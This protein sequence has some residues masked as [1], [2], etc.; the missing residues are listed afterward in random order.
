MEYHAC[1]RDILLLSSIL[2]SKSS[3]RAYQRLLPQKNGELL[4][5]FA[6]QSLRVFTESQKK[7]SEVK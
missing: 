3:L 6:E 4:D 1:R 7:F 2:Y 5:A